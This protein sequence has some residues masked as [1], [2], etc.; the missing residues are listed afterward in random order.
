MLTAQGSTPG[1][2]PAYMARI[3][4][5]YITP[6]EMRLDTWAPESYADADAGIVR[7][8]DTGERRAWDLVAS[9]QDSADGWIHLV[10]TSSPVLLVAV[11]PVNRIWGWRTIEYFV[12][13]PRLTIPVH[14]RAYETAPYTDSEWW[15]S[16]ENPDTPA[17]N[18]E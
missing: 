2:T 10:V 18:N 9:Q 1:V 7:H 4:A 3:Y 12:P 8:L 14:F 6:E 11:D 15:L 13:L 16:P 5:F 17:E